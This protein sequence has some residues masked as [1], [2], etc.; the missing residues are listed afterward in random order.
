MLVKNSFHFYECSKL[1]L[2]L[3]PKS[4][5]SCESPHDEEQTTVTRSSFNHTQTKGNFPQLTRHVGY[6]VLVLKLPTTQTLVKEKFDLKEIN[7]RC[8]QSKHSL[9]CMK[10][11]KINYEVKLGIFK[12]DFVKRPPPRIER[13][14]P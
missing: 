8:L 4:L 14:A 3:D 5:P 10:S 9:S 12:K 1:V 13:I 11:F 2:L 7:Q 6:Q